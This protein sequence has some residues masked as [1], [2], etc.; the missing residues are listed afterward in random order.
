MTSLIVPITVMLLRGAVTVLL[1]AAAEKLFNRVLSARSRRNL[2]IYCIILM[3]I[4][5]PEWQFQP[6]VIDMTCFRDLVIDTADL[7]PRELA[8]L[9]GDSPTVYAIA[10]Y[11][12]AI[13]GVTAHSLIY[14]IAMCCAVMLAI[15]FL[16]ASYIK[17]RR[18]THRLQPVSDQRILNIWRKIVPAGGK[19]PLLLDSKDA[20][21]PPVLFGFFRQKLLLPEAHLAK[22]SDSELELLLTHEYIHYRSGDG[23][24]N[25]L[26][27]A[28]WPLC[29]YNLFFLLARR[30][31]R[32]SCEL[33]CDDR[34][35]ARYPER[36]AEYGKLLLTFADTV[37]APPVTV[38][39]RETSGE[40]KIRIQHMACPI[41]NKCR[42][43]NIFLTALLV[44]L[45]ASP[46]TIFSAVV[47]SDGSIKS[48]ATSQISSNDGNLTE[49]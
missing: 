39:F 19:S 25:V 37:Q 45:L 23:I 44:L 20:V 40:L 28:L 14:F 38:P 8:L 15:V 10:E 47:K 34:V 1:L 6:L 26:T 49:K 30:R 18:K 46:L 36:T 31:W 24:I 17:C 21:H 7:L 32:I 41:R 27:L 3:F 33:A 5:Q 29:W 22:L 2:W 42:K 13:P 43:G 16:L 48:S 4:P 35:L 12:M 11:F 9:V